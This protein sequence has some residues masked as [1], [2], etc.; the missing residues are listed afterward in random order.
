MYNILAK[1][2]NCLL[3]LP[4]QVF[5]PLA[6]SNELAH[7]LVRLVS[8]SAPLCIWMEEV[9]SSISPLVAH[10]VVKTFLPPVNAYLSFIKKIFSHFGGHCFQYLY[11]N[12]FQLL[13]AML[14]LF[15][16]PF[17][18]FFVWERDSDYILQKA[19][20]GKLKMNNWWV[21][22]HTKQGLICVNHCQKF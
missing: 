7:H 12:K 19:A 20:V 5:K 21:I 16:T 6:T 13:V 2:L 11:E 17:F 1:N 14:V 18:L 15:L 9:P 4:V 3:N 10:D 8:F 22:S